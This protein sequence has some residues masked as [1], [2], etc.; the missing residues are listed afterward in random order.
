MIGFIAIAIVMILGAVA[1]VV[2]PLFRNAEARAPVAGLVA[3]LSI[4]AA[5]AL[6][7]ASLSSYPWGGVAPVS[8]AATAASAE[9]GELQR[10]TAEHPEDTTAWLALAQRYMDEERFADARTAF[11]RAGELDPE[12]AEAKL[13]GAEAAILLDRAALNAEAGQAIEQVLVAE[14]ANPKALWYSGMAALGRGDKVAAKDRW[15]RLLAL[16]PPEQVRQIIEAQLAELSGQ[17]WPEARP[18]PDTADAGMRLAVRIS[19]APGL[20]SRVKVGAPVFLIARDPDRPGPPVAVVRREAATLPSTLEITD[21]DLMLP[22]Q[23]LTDLAQIRLTARVANGG[24]ARAMSG[25]VF[26]ETLW[27]RGAVTPLEITMDSVVP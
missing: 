15:E 19:V 5:A 22:G 1:L 9:T 26:G 21:A 8:R 12:N 27:T 20:V 16:S 2:V 10:R 11:S 24:D 6:L 17:G 3:A 4:P 14:P 13:G 7:Y 25:D 18:K 23:T